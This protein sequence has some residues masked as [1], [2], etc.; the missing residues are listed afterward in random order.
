MCV[1]LSQKKLRKIWEKYAEGLPD[2]LME[3]SKSRVDLMSIC[4]QRGHIQMTSALGGEGLTQ[5]LTQILTKADKGNGANQIRQHIW[6]PYCSSTVPL[7][8][9]WQRLISCFQT[10]NK[11]TYFFHLWQ[12]PTK[13]KGGKKCKCRM[14]YMAPKNKNIDDP[15]QYG[16]VG[17]KGWYTSALA[18]GCTIQP[19]FHATVELARVRSCKSKFTSDR[20]P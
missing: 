20:L 17:V 1:P 3:C 14:Y 16:E 9:L 18:L 15:V 2:N 4:M 8:W 12:M 10:L 11:F 7:F 19:P 5:G 6:S 13:G